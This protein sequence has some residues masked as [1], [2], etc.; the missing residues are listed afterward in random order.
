MLKLSLTPGEYVTIGD[1]IVVQLYKTD[2]KRSFFA[3]QAP[4]DVP[5]LRGAVAEREG[6]PRPKGLLQVED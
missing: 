3:I 2:G 1:G 5:V 6:K 4:K